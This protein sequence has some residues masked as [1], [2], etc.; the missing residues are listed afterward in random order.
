MAQQETPTREFELELEQQA[1]QHSTKSN[2]GEE[3]M[4]DMD[5]ETSAAA[6]MNQRGMPKSK[7]WWKKIQTGRLNLFY[8]YFMQRIFYS[9][10]PVSNTAKPKSTWMKKMKDRSLNKQVRTL[11]E[12]IRQKLT[13]E[14][15]E[16]RQKEKE[17]SER[18]KANQSKAEIVQIV[19]NPSKLK[20]MN[21]KQLK[22]IRKKDITK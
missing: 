21:R 8:I 16:K 10:R 3:I 20:K 6:K 15:A 22:Q 1:I 13:E 2:Q 12:G 11:Q 17:K 7:R 19:K 18:R 5:I 14:K 4:M 9:L